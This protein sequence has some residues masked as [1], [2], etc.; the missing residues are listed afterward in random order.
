MGAH[1]WLAGLALG[2]APAPA[3]E[4]P[5]AP[6]APPPAVQEVP[7]PPQDE[8]AEAVRAWVAGR[9]VALESTAADAPTPGADLAAISSALSGVRVVGLGEANH[10]TAEFF[11]FRHRLLRHLVREGYRVV[12]FESH[13]SGSAAVDDYI[14]GGAS[15]LEEAMAGLGLRVWQ[16]E[17]LAALLR[18]LR[19]HNQGVPPA[20]RVRFVGV[21][22]QGVDQPSA[23]IQAYL[24]RVDPALAEADL[25]FYAELV[26]AAQ[27]AWAGEAGAL[28]GRPAAIE[29][30]LADFVLKRG[31]YVARSSVAEYE[32]VLDELCIAAQFTRTFGGGAPDAR[33]RAMADNVLAI[34][35]DEPTAKIAFLAHNAHVQRGELA[36][37]APG[38]LAA[39]EH[40]ARDLGG[41]YYAL[42]LVLGQG[43]F[44]ALE[45]D[46][47]GAWQF[48]V[49]EVGPPPPSTAEW[50]FASAG[51][52][53]AFLDLRAGPRP[54]PVQA[55]LDEPR[56]LRWA[57]GYAVPA[58]IGERWKV[59]G[60]VPRS[61]IP[62]EF[63]GLVY[64]AQVRR[65]SPLP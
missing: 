21:D 1:L 30:R 62:L 56:G 7:Q 3:Q 22:M 13:H 44:Q 29:A 61:R 53:D 32:R 27:R 31:R 51:L 63:D 55:W 8:Q 47:A 34:L 36:S 25:A 46:A 40:L 4:G 49:Y 17:E 37:A 28:E 33:D 35:A 12:A 54:A 9:S 45:Q 10:G 58:N 43:T 16:V 15:S 19:E 60:N 64:V 24:A 14:H 18:W 5:P 65:A 26:A 42:G 41:A 6:D 23:A 20:E 2:A 38:H 50:L 39:G 59:S 11:S 57:G 52:G 48:A